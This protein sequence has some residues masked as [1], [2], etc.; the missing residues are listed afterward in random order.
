[1][2]LEL[3]KFEIDWIVNRFDYKFDKIAMKYFGLSFTLV[4]NIRRN[5][6]DDKAQKCEMVKRWMR[7]N[8]NN[9]LE[10][11]QTNNQWI[12]RSEE[13]HFGASYAK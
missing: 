4:E 10:V 7:K 2:L 11:C 3:D 13:F 5:D 9:R 8:P 6:K 12:S 1:M